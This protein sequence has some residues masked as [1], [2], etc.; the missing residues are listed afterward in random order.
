MKASTVITSQHP[1]PSVAH[2][3]CGLRPKGCT[4]RNGH[5]PVWHRSTRC[6]SSA[7]VE[8]AKLDDRYLVRDAKDLG[9]RPLVFTATGWH[10]FT[11]GLRAGTFD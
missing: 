6:G 2:E 1:G 3:I 9:T 10:A 8:V 4:M 11:A 5:E 7:C